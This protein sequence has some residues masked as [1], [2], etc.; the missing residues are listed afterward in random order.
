MLYRRQGCLQSAMLSEPVCRRAQLLTGRQTR[1]VARVTLAD[2]QSTPFLPVEGELYWV[3]T[4]I[5]WSGDR[6]ATRPVVV[7]ATP[8]TTLGRVQVVTRTTDLSRK[9]VPHEAMPEA[10]LTKCGVFAD[11]RSSEATLWTPQNARKLGVLPSP[12]FYKVQE[13]FG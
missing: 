7:I 4:I 6:K 5:L 9:G 1:M 10:G 13:R 3:Q 12:V 2:L 8:A 11:L